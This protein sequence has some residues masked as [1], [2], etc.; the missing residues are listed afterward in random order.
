MKS[1]VV[2]SLA[3][4]LVLGG[5]S[6]AV[7]LALVHPSPASAQRPEDASAPADTEQEARALFEAGRIAYENGRFADALPSFTRA[8]ELTGRPALI[9][10]IGQC[11][12]RLGRSAEAAD[13]YRRFLT[14]VPD[15][16]NRNFLE[17]RLAILDAEAARAT[18]AAPVE[19]DAP[20]AQPSD[21]QPSDTQ[22]SDTQPSDTEATAPTRALAVTPA[23]ATRATATDDTPLVAAVVLL[24][25]GAAVGVAALGTGLA[26]EARHAALEAD[27]PGRVCAPELAPGIDELRTLGL[28]TDALLGVGGA[29]LLSGA[30]TLVVHLVQPRA[31]M[32]AAG[33]GLRIAF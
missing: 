20:D 19:R 22:P 15:A 24:G 9:F 17:G 6:L 10:N 25:L 32:R 7:A 26:A 11:L 1:P 33:P 31:T 3:A 18:R 28:A 14:A 27:C 2:S 13:A 29:L 21:T 8:F 12:D 16:P 30:V 4:V 23:D 5:L